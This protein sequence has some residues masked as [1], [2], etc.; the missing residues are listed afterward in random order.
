MTGRDPVWREGA[1]LSQSDCV[2]L[3]RRES[4]APERQGGVHAELLDRKD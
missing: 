2:V 1:G 4:P 3:S